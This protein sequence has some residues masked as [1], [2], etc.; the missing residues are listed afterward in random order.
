M[1]SSSY[2][3]LLFSEMWW[4]YCCLLCLE[5]DCWLNEMGYGLGRIAHQQQLK[6]A[7][8]THSSIVLQQTY[9]L[10]INQWTILPRLSS[11]LFNSWSGKERNG[12]ISGDCGM[13]WL[14]QGR[15]PLITHNFMNFSCGRRIKKLFQQYCVNDRR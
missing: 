8:Q 9:S 15:L 7:K 1:D 12:T 13:E 2:I 11:L 3:L 14:E 10:F 5:L 4:I 6:K